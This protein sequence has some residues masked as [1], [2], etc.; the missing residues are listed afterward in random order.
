M[1]TDTDNTFR[2]EVIEAFFRFIRNITGNPLRSELCFAD[3]RRELFNMHRCEHIF[4]QHTAGNQNSVFVVI[5]VPRHKADENIA[6]ECEFSLIGCR[7]VGNDIPDFYMLPDGNNRPL[8][9][10]RILIST[11]IFQQCII[12]DFHLRSFRRIGFDGNLFGGNECNRT[13]PLRFD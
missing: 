7:A 8:M 12:A 9:I 5:P 1:C 10:T 11:L 3:F 6:A 4:F 13:A 2:V